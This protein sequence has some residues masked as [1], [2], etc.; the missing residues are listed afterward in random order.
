MQ[1]GLMEGLPVSL[2]IR[3]RIL[4]DAASGAGRFLGT[5]EVPEYRIGYTLAR[6]LL[7]SAK[8]AAKN[9]H[10]RFSNSDWLKYTHCTDSAH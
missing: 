3:Q 8:V 4:D 1:L 10:L 2:P 6:C 5:P 7:S 9:I